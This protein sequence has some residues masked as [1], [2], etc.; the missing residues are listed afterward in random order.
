MYSFYARKLKYVIFHILNE[1]RMREQW[2]I[3]GFVFSVNMAKNSSVLKCLK[4]L[5]TMS[6]VQLHAWLCFDTPENRLGQNRQLL[7]SFSSVFFLV[8]VRNAVKVAITGI[9]CVLFQFIVPISLCFFSVMPF[10][11]NL[12]WDAIGNWKC[13][14]GHILCN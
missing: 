3:V 2:S 10:Y 6:Y 13:S 14:L 7:R 8:R 12:T 5:A 1:D 9:N 11:N 4:Y